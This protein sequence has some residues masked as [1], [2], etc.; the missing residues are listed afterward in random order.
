[1]RTG[2]VWSKPAVRGD[3]AAAGHAVRLWSKPVVRGGRA[4]A[5]RAGRLRSEAAPIF[6]LA[7][8]AGAGFA[9]TAGMA[10]EAGSGARGAAA[11]QHAHG[12]KPAQSASAK[13]GATQGATPKPGAPQKQGAAEQAGAQGQSS[14]AKPR[15]LAVDPDHGA[16]SLPARKQAQLEAA[17]KYGVFHDF[18]FADKLRESAITFVHKV[19][20]D[21]GRT[22]KAVHYDHGN[23]IA[24]ADV[25]GDGLYDLYFTNQVGGNQLWKN[26]GAGKFRDITAAAGVRVPGR[27]SVTASFADTDNDGD[28]DLFVTTVRGG[29][30]LFE[31]DGR[32]RFTDVTASAGVGLKLH[33]SGAVFFDYNNDGLVDLFVCNVGRYTNEEIGPDGEYG[34]LADAFQGHLYANR[35]EVSV[36][37]KNLGK[38]RFQDVSAETGLRDRSWSGD[39][40]FTDFNGDGWPDLYILNMQGDDHYYE[41]SGGKTFSDR[42]AAHFPKTPWGSMG[43]KFFDFD[44]DG[45]MDLYVTDMHSD[46]WEHVGMER[47]KLKSRRQPDD[48]VLQGGANNIFGNAFYRNLGDGKFEEVSDRVGAE[49]YWPWGFS[50]GDVNADGAPD[51]FVTASMNYPFRYGINS[52]LL[53]DGGKAFVDAEFVLGIEPRR[54]G[55]VTPWF[56]VDCAAL[57]A[58]SPFRANCEGHTG[59][60]TL[61]G[62][63]GSRASV[64]VDLDNDGDLDIVTSEFNSAPQVLISNLSDRRKIRWLKV[65]LAG[66]ASNRGGLG[67]TVRVRAGGK[68]YVQYHDGKSGYLSQSA[69]PLYF[70]LG[71]A[72]AVESVEV[73]W[74]SGRKQTVRELEPNQ[75]LFVTEPE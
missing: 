61:M 4:A 70:G 50:V 53:N 9:A 7:A 63:L 74:P 41:N 75:T 5:V 56:D 22:Y 43:V 36:L 19:V 26:L 44:G 25:D 8:I 64:M 40:T 33:S 1:M 42:T 32:G 51:V 38:N 48:R 34:G 68:T 47:E 24:A 6:L 49:N 60:I 67:A 3:N 46:M 45:R 20:S 11:V 58:E 28:V 30:L 73:T 69:L 59:A 29:N 13:P 21:A 66:R 17:K 27:I 57:E 71:N 2:R 54:E 62:T 37:Y 39:A 14:G 10:A 23:G 16:D 72:E 35:A 31:N 15:V 52:L 18:T 65:A 12:E 55:T